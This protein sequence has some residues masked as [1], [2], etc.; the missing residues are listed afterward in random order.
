MELTAERKQ[1]LLDTYL[2]H[3]NM[4]ELSELAGLTIT[5]LEFLMKSAEIYHGRKVM[6]GDN[7]LQKIEVFREALI[8][9]LKQK[10][11]IYAAFNPKTGYPH[12]MGDGTVMMF[13]EKEYAL[14]AK[15]HY[16]EEGL[17]LDM[18]IIDKERQQLI[19][20][21]FFWW[22]M[23]KIALDVGCYSCTLDRAMILPPPDYSNLPKIQVPVSNP[24]LVFSMVRHRQHLFEENKDERWKKTEQYLTHQMLKEMVKAKFLCPTK[25]NNPNGTQPDAEGKM[26]IGEG[27]TIQFAVLTDKEGKQWFPAFTDW[28]SFQKLYDQKEWDGQVVSYEDLLAFAGANGVVVNPGGMET[29]LDE[30]RKGMVSLYLNRYKRLT[31][32]ME[33][34]KLVEKKNGFWIGEPKEQP[35]ELQKL[36]SECMKKHKEIK[37]AYLLIKIEHTDDLSYLLIVDFKGDRDAVFGAI[38]DAVRE[39]LDY[40]RLDMHE[41]D[42]KMMELAGECKPFYKK[43]FLGL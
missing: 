26:K 39:H 43:S 13:S 40:M 6:A 17:E 25:L 9:S 31:E 7:F 30:R 38:S 11:N 24:K 2:L 35:E 33:S 42:D 12:I 23:E 14:K 4:P 1:E 21:D 27:A 20:A 5:E 8:L 41:A 16:D 10:D 34:G 22:G 18:K 3:Y 19:W 28:R 15:E 29:K 37:K 36:L 32:E